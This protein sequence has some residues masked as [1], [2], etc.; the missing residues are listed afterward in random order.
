MNKKLTVKEVV[1]CGKC[2]KTIG[3]RMSDGSFHILFGRKRN[4]SEEK[5]R[6]IIESGGYILKRNNRFAM[7]VFV[8]GSVQIRCSSPYCDHTTVVFT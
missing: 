6:E 2:G 7:E 3:K 1:Y 8:K 4:L 5:K